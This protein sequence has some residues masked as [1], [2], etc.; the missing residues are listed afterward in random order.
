VAVVDSV[1]AAPEA[2]QVGLEAEVVPAGAAARMAAAVCGKPGRRRAAAA[3]LV[4]EAESQAVAPE[5]EGEA[6]AVVP[7]AED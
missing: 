1:A 3:A 2:G 7:E 6:A 5:P 4:V